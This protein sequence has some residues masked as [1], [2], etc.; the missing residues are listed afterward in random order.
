M[1][2]PVAKTHPTE[3]VFTVEA[4]HVVAAAVLLNADVALGAVLGVG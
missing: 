4:L 3:V 2:P 1:S